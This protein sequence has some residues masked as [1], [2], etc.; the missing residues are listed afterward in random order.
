MKSPRRLSV[1]KFRLKKEQKKTMM[2]MVMAMAM[3]GDMG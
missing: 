3:A 2:A 1:L